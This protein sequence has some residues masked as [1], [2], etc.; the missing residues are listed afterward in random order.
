M[1]RPL[2]FAALVFFLALPVSA[3]GV[4]IIGTELSDNGDGDGYADTYETVSLRVTVQNTT[5]LDLQDV[6]LRLSSTSPEIACISRPLVYLGSLAAGETRRV[7]DDFVFT[8]GEIDRTDLGLDEFSDLTANFQV[9]VSS[10]RLNELANVPTN[11]ITTI[12]L[13]LDLDVMGGSGRTTFLETFESGTMGTFSN[14]NLDAGRNSLAAS[15]GY[16][17]QYADPDW[18]GS[19]S[20]GQVTDCFLGANP[21][22][23]DATFW[24]VRAARGFSGEHSLHFGIELDPALGYTTPLG[25]LEAAG[26]TDPINLAWA[27][28][29][30]GDGVTECVDEFDCPTGESCVHAQQTL[31]FKHQVDLP[32]SRNVNAPSGEA[33]DRAVVQ[34]QLADELGQPVG[35]W[36]KLQPYLNVYDQTAVDNYFNCTF[37]PI[38]DGNTE[39]DFFDPTDPDRRLGP[40]STCNPEPIFAHMGDTDTPYD[41]LELGNAEGPGLEGT[42]GPGTWV[43]SKF[44][45]DRFKGRRLRLR[46]LVSALKAGA[47]RRERWCGPTTRLLVTTAGGS[48]T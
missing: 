9:H 13:S 42:T 14:L 43:E 33:S 2:I 39:D 35:P 21:Q 28:V 31:S 37:D 18:R 11:A 8:I 25:V 45:L 12:T 38:D 41:P 20:Y 6:V 46:F 30:E 3:D 15:D 40:S 10:D 32:D 4:A 44:N 1:I 23:T 7:D 48:T 27:K 36:I 5:E 22:Q 17:C 24:Q 19:N 47:G 26:M 34:L 29:C 16:R